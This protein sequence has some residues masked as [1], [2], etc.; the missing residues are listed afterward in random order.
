MVVGAVISHGADG[1]RP[2][3]LY[4]VM[5]GAVEYLPKANFQKAT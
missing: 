3:C 1:I 2:I 4:F 5:G